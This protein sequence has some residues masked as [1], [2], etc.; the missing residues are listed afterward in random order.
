MRSIQLFRRAGLV[1]ASGALLLV[2]GG[3]PKH[4]NFP[5]ALDVDVPPTPANFAITVAPGTT[6][7]TFEWEISD[8]AGVKNYRLYVIGLSL[9]PE[10][11]AEPTT[12]TVSRTLPYSVAGLQFGVSAVSEGNIEGTMVI[13]DAP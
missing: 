2:L 4:E 12:T 3:C 5:T 13:A 10:L 9:L 6:D 8:P 7:Y 11:L 1:M